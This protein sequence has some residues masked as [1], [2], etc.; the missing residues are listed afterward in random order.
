MTALS[1]YVVLRSLPLSDHRVPGVSTPQ[2][3]CP[4]YHAWPAGKQSDATLSF[5]K[6]LTSS[7]KIEMLEA[8]GSLWML[9]EFAASIFTVE[10][11]VYHIGDLGAFVSWKCMKSEKRAW[12]RLRK[13]RE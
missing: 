12:V 5:S 2:H 13:N 1:H 9:E 6:R 7:L 10:S 4:T 3:R 11:S 8:V